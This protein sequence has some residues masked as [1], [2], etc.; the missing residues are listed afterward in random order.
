MQASKDLYVCDNLERNSNNNKH[1]NPVW[2]WAQAQFILG[3]IELSMSCPPKFSTKDFE[4]HATWQ[5][6]SVDQ[7]LINTVE[8]LFRR[9]CAHHKHQLLYINL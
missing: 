4:H 6:F 1:F 9:Q 5:G 3:S 7:G 2:V 8:T